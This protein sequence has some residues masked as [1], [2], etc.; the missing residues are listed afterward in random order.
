MRYIVYEKC[1]KCLNTETKCLNVENIYMHESNIF[2]EE[3]KVQEITRKS[4][5]FFVHWLHWELPTGEQPKANSSKSKHKTY[6]APNV[7]I[8]Y[9]FDTTLTFWDDSSLFIFVIPLVLA[10]FTEFIINKLITFNMF[11]IY[12]LRAPKAQ[13]CN[14]K[15]K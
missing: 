6:F 14:T 3:T 1:Y 4:R 10:H 2:P 9:L 8:C 13:C 12:L 11:A 15:E 7:H 5:T